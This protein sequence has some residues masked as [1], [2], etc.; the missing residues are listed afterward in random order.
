MKTVSREELKNRLDG[1]EPIQLVMALEPWAYERL[2]IPGSMNFETAFQAAQHLNRDREVVVY[3]ANPHCPASYRMY[4][5]LASSGFTRIVRFAGGIEA[6]LEAGL[7][8][9]GSLAAELDRVYA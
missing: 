4:Y 6:W 9:E 7:P 1:A 5:Y 3:C 2:H 8:V